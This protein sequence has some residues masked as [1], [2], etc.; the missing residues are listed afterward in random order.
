[1]EQKVET[2]FGVEDKGKRQKKVS[3]SAAEERLDW[4]ITFLDT[5]DSTGGGRHSSSFWSMVLLLLLLLLLLLGYNGFLNAGDDNE[6]KSG[7]RIEE[8][9]KF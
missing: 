9:E 3:V 6:Y 4:K 2:R 1:V 5:A 8:G 7:C